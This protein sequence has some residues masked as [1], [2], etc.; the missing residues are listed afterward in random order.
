L[1]IARFL[2]ARCG[3]DHGSRAARTRT[4]VQG[5]VT[6]G[7]VSLLGRPSSGGTGNADPL[8]QQ[9]RGSLRALLGVPPIRAQKFRLDHIE[10][11]GERG[12]RR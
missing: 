12:I 11:V 9:A 8:W 10:D 4:Q 3:Q 5:A 2:A 7:L 1:L 6:V